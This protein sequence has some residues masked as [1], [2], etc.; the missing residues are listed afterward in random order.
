MGN[1]TPST[2][3]FTSVKMTGNIEA[4]PGGTAYFGNSVNRWGS[5]FSAAYTG[6]SFNGTTFTGAAFV[7][8]TISGT[9]ISGTSVSVTGAVS[10]S[11]FAGGT[12]SGTTYSGTTYNGTNFLGSGSFGGTGATFTGTSSSALYAD[13]AERYISDAQ[14]VP[15]TVVELGGTAEI[16]QSVYALSENVFGVI[17]T[18]PA[19]LMN[20]G[21][22]N[23]LPVALVGRVPVRVIGTVKKGDRLVS[24]GNGVARSAAHVELTPFNVIGRSLVDKTTTGEELI[25]VVVKIN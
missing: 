16:T 17:S 4:P 6:T 23:G 8:G 13:L 22:A 15:G 7:G 2:G 25:E 20:S 24:A 10:A 14:Y 5:V 21:L 3:A 18:D 12:F 19:Y 9:T 11:S 1:A